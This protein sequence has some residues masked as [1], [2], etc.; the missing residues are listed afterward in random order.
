MASAI[1][2]VNQMCQRAFVEMFGDVFEQT[3]SIALKAWT[4][5]PFTDI[6]DQGLAGVFEM[7]KAGAIVR[8]VD[9]I[10]RNAVEVV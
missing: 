5:R 8:I 3:P 6:N 4:K 2:E 9:S 7:E 10:N 1:S